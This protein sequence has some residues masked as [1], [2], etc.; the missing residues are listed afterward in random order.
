M[1][2]RFNLKTGK[3]TIDGK[4]C[5]EPASFTG[6]ENSD[7]LETYKRGWPIHSEAAG[8]HP[9]Q[10]PEHIEFDRHHGV[11]TDYDS[12]GRPILRDRA[13][14]KRYLKIHGLRDNQGGYGD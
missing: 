11:P 10:I 13:H 4:P 3:W 6:T 14:R 12:T 1:K 9:S 8:A 5:K 2:K 7:K